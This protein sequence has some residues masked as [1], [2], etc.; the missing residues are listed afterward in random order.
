[1][2]TPVSCHRESLNFVQCVYGRQKILNSTVVYFTYKYVSFLSSNSTAVLIIICRLLVKNTR[3]TPLNTQDLQTLFC[4]LPTMGG[5]TAI[6]A[7]WLNSCQMQLGIARRAMIAAEP[8]Y[9]ALTSIL[10][11]THQNETPELQPFY[12]HG[13]LGLKS[14]L[15]NWFIKLILIISK[16]CPEEEISHHALWT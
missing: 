5:R 13:Y 12:Q 7:N 10:S 3:S 4:D 14:I 8:P 9:T 15:C 2:Y 16:L 11:L 6:S 1:M